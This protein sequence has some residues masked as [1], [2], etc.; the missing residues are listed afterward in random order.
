M[1]NSEYTDYV[2]INTTTEQDE[3]IIQ[4]ALI[5]QE[6]IRSGREQYNPITNNCAQTI[7]ECI[8]NGTG[9]DIK[10]GITPCP[11]DKFDNIKQSEKQK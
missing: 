11:N 9:I 3:K 4:N 7:I 5:K 6:K 10:D 2:T 8:E 1:D